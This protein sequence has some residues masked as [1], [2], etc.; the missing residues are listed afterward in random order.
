MIRRHYPVKGAALLVSTTAYEGA[1]GK[2]PRGRGYWACFFGHGRG[3]GMCVDPWFCPGERN[4]AE[5]RT[6]AVNEAGAR[7]F[8]WVEVGSGAPFARRRRLLPL[9]PNSRSVVARATVVLRSP[10]G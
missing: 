9:P 6:L 2:P 3:S 1:H 7:G 8:T 10:A 5:A 4:Y